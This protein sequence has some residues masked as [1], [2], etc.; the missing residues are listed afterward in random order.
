MEE[1]KENKVNYKVDKIRGIREKLFSSPD[2]VE[3]DFETFQ[4]D[5]KYVDNIWRTKLGKRGTDIINGFHT[6]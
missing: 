1:D 4:S 3:V 2:E 6:Y 5:W